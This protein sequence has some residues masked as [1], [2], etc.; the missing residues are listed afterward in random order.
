M[1]RKSKEVH[2]KSEEMHRKSEE[3]RGNTVYLAQGDRK[4]KEITRKYRGNTEEM[5]RKSKEMHRR[6]IGNA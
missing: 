5:H 1:P 3:I 2:R 6:S 4:P